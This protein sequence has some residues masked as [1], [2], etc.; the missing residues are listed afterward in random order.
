MND[1]IKLWE[2]GDPK[3]GGRPV[4]SIDQSETENALEEAL[5]NSPDMLMQGLTLVGRQTPTDSGN[6]DLL[7]VDDDGRLVVFE[8]K[9]GN[10]TRDAIV[11]IVDYCSSLESLPDTELAQHIA[12]HSGTRGVDKIDDFETWYDI[13]RGKPLVEL[14]PI[15][16]VLVGIGADARTQRMVDYLAK[17]NVDITLLTFHGYSHGGKTLL[18]RQVEGRE[19]VHE[20]GPGR[21]TGQAELRNMHAETAKERGIEDLWQEAVSTLSIPFNSTATRSGIS[22]SLPG[23]SLA[24]TTPN[25]EVRFRA[26][27]S[28][29]MDQDDRIRVTFYPIA[30]H[31]CRK[32]EDKKNEIGFKCETPL[33]APTTER[34]TDQWYCQLDRNGW[35]QRK[36]ALTGLV[37][38]VHD[39]WQEVR[40]NGAETQ[41]TV[42]GAHA[43]STA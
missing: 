32:V 37:N 19:E 42:T 11:Q 15:R 5:V 20:P 41:R 43:P 3:E 4:E 17:R 33:H 16:M 1:E 18:A 28:V 29:A 40:R 6:L 31:L 35:N 39:K 8:L 9:R 25:E 10:L 38:E 36:K 2:I 7:G 30:V 22:F 24:G 21:R 34:V 27:H 23:I 26:T 14:R 12:S 13:R